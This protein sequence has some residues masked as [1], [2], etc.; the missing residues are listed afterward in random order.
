MKARWW[1][2]WLGCLSLCLFAQAAWAQERERITDFSSE[3][4]VHEDATMAVTETIKVMVQGF[5]IKRGII[6]DFPTKYKDSEGRPVTVWFKLKEVRRDGVPEPYEVST[7]DNGVSIRI[8]DAEYYLPYGEHTYT[9]VYETS[10]QLGF[11]EGYDELYW[12]VTGNGWTFTM[13]H[14]SAEVILPE[15]VDTAGVRNLAYTGPYGGHGDSFEVMTQGNR[16]KFDTTVPLDRYEGLTIVTQWPAGVVARPTKQQ[17]AGYWLIEHL[18]RLLCLAGLLVVGL[19]YFSTWLRLGI[20]PHR[21]FITPESSPPNGLSP[22]ALRYI[23]HMSADRKCFTATLVSL[24]TRGY[25]NIEDSSG[26]YTLARSGAVNVQLPAEEQQVAANLFNGTDRLT[27]DQDNQS[28]LVNAQDALGKSL[29]QQYDGVYF[30]RHGDKLSIGVAL[31]AISVVLAIVAL[32]IPHTGF[33]ILAILGAVAGHIVLF[34]VFH[35]L[36]PAYTRLGRAFLDR[37]EGFKLAL[38]GGTDDLGDEHL[39]SG[40]LVEAYLPYAIA[41]EVHTPWSRHFEQALKLEQERQGLAYTGFHPV[42]YIGDWSNFDAKGTGGF[43]RFSSQ[44]TSSFNSQISSASTPPG[45]SSGGS[46]GFSGGGGGG[47]GGSGW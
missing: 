26:E 42:W 31:S 35:A 12:N 2:L 37:I 19:Y 46:S 20:D 33:P 18:V 8:G 6:R 44:F 45:S 3:I 7:L 1:L 24:A 41:L 43:S 36:L 29:K 17:L 38:S 27:I 14:A 25:L 47:G 40:V 13:D 22:A 23:T 4:V 16:V 10:R 30:N 34:I 28:V 39:G 21:G 9:I 32:F 5:E 11:F 15:G